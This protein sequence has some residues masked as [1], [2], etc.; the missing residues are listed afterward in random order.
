VEKV[1][2]Q[3]GDE[4]RDYRVVDLDQMLMR[5]LP[6]DP[7]EAE[8][9]FPDIVPEIVRKIPPHRPPRKPRPKPRPKP[10]RDADEQEI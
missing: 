1:V 6:V 9:I 2:R 3:L 10:R 5:R 4:A 8:R 7:G